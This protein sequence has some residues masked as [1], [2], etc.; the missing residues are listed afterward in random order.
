MS[1]YAVRCFTGEEIEVKEMLKYTLERQQCHFVKAIHAFETFTQVF[2]GKSTARKEMKSAVPGYIFVETNDNF[3]L[4]RKE[5]WHLIKS[6]PKVCQIF[7]NEIPEEEMDY[8]FETCDVEPDIEVRLNHDT[9]TE[10][11]KIAAEQ[12]ALHQ[13]NVK[14]EQ[15]ETD[16][17]ETTVD[18]VHDLQEQVKDE[19]ALKRM[20]GRCKAYIQRKK[21]TFVF[22]FSLFHKTRDRIDPNKQMT[23]RE[24]TDGDFIIPELVKTLK[25]EVSLQ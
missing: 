25:M 5:L 10:E 3:P 2:R 13:A 17:T 14:G 21:E 11:Q 12:E 6:I 23:I 1:I 7:R 8:F 15:V 16:V 20:I 4:M 18:Q 19:S 24:L 22:P 9:Q